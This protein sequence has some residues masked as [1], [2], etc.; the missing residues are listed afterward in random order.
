M[1]D[2]EVLL[3]HATSSG[4]AVLAF[5]APELVER[6]LAAPLE[7]RTD[8][9][10]TDA[11]AIRELLPQIKQNGYAV[12]TG[13]FEKDVC[14]HAVPLFDAASKC[15]GAVAIVAPENRVTDAL[16][17][18]IVHTVQ[19]HTLQLTRALGGFPPPGFPEVSI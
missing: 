17:Q 2:A 13:G 12:S 8:Q 4:H 19:S 18:T 16:R 11:A 6:T 14:S 7:A 1:E 15:I 3:L 5:G 9:T 10:I